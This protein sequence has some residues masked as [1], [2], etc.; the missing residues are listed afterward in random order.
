MVSAGLSV[1]E[2]GSERRH[3]PAGQPI[4]QT[5]NQISHPAHECGAFR[6]VVRGHGLHMFEAGQLR[7]GAEAGASA[8]CGQHVLDIGAGR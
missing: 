5:F 1:I 7:M 8:D 3:E 4:G 6:D 2:V